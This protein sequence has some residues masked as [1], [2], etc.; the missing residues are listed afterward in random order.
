MISPELLIILRIL[1]NDVLGFSIVCG[2]LTPIIFLFSRD[3]GL[4]LG[5]AVVIAF[6]L[7]LDYFAIL[8]ELRKRGA[9][10]ENEGRHEQ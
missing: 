9:A 1:A 2:I 10:E 7:P 8:R 6:V 3:W 5:I 4:A